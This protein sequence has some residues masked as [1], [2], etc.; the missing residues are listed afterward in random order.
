MGDRLNWEAVAAAIRRMREAAGPRQLAAV[1]AETAGQLAPRTAV[2]LASDN[3]LRLAAAAG[4]EP[5]PGGVEIPAGSAPALAEALQTGDCVVA[6]H[7]AT[8]LSFRLVEALPAEPGARV[9]LAP[10]AGRRTAHGILYAEGGRAA[11]SPAPFEALA[12]AAGLAADALSGE[13]APP[14]GLVTLGT[15]PSGPQ[16]APEAVDEEALKREESARRFARVRVAAILERRSQA[17]KEGRAAGDLYRRLQA[18]IEQARGAYKA[19]YVDKAGLATDYLHE[20]LVRTLAGNDAS[21]LGADYPGPL[22]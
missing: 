5:D 12:G 21:L 9:V 20:E 8:E 16:A 4:F 3:L 13:P 7:A 10:I 2:F 6:M 14:E 15:S 18:E 1:L 19:E 22:V 11:E 17:V